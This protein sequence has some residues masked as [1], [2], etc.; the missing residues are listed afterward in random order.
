LSE[1]WKRERQN[2]EIRYRSSEMASICR[3]RFVVQSSA[4][5]SHGRRYRNAA[6]PQKTEGRI[7][8]MSTLASGILWSHGIARP[9]ESAVERTLMTRAPSTAEIQME[10]DMCG[11]SSEKEPHEMEA[12]FHGFLYFVN[13][14]RSPAFWLSKL[15]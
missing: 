3:T 15:E 6:T 2:P 9:R 12:H 8:A 13:P 1:S 4:R 11:I 10:L 5:S 14:L 7:Q